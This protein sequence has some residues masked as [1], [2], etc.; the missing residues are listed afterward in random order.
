MIAPTIASDVGRTASGSS[1]SSM[2][3]P[4]L[5]T[6]ATSGAKPSTCSASFIRNSRGIS[7]GKA[8]F[9]CPLSLIMSSKARWI[10][11]HI[12]QPYG[13]TT[14]MP[15]TPD[16][17][18][19]SALRMTSVYQRSKST[20]IFVTSL[21]K[22]CCSSVASISLIKFPR[23]YI[24]LESW[25]TPAPEWCAGLTR[26]RGGG[27]LCCNRVDL[28]QQHGQEL[29]GRHGPVQLTSLED[30]SLAAA[31]G[32]PDVGV[33]RLRR[34][35]HDAA[36]H[37]NRDRQLQPCD[38]RLDRLHGRHHVVLEA[39]A[40]GACDEGRALVAERQGLEDLVRD[41]HLLAR[42][43]RRQRHADRIADP[44]A[45][46]DPHPDRAPN[47]AGLNRT[48]LRH[49]EVDGVRACGGELAVRHDVG[50]DIGRLQRDLDIARPVVE[51]LEDLAVAEGHLDHA[52]CG[53]LPIIA[54]DLVLLA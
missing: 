32:N 14:I 16:Q 11:S 23:A 12:A 35:V 9:S 25:S 29:F 34:P 8:Q 10:A 48:G 30:H 47:A 46:Q 13:R 50:P 7:S 40:G 4:A 1:S 21:T 43:R 36:H 28:S 52:V 27:V 20:D 15:R 51:V 2:R 5:V 19:S 26:G 49:A 45:E 6:H 54:V 31:T 44:L 37:G 41:A 3:A 22:S 24:T 17:S 38:V 42:I 53:P 33:P 39:A 18:A